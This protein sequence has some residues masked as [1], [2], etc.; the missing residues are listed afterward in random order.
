MMGVPMTCANC[1]RKLPQGAIVCPYCGVGL[2]DVPIQK[3]K[4]LFSG[5]LGIFML[6]GLM[7]SCIAWGLMKA[8]DGAAGA[9][10]ASTQAAPRFS[11]D[12]SDAMQT[13]RRD[14]MQKLVSTG[15]VQ[16]YVQ[17]GSHV[18][19]WITPAFRLLDFDQ[20]KA[21]AEV[22]WC[23]YFDGAHEFR[24]LNIHDS[25]SGKE[26]GDFNPHTGLDL[27]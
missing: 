11:V 17:R 3:S 9:I 10:Q 7:F 15:V 20:K 25:K 18:E 8:M 5:C 21:F 13:E 19:M 24:S 23:Y 22:V 6:G 4:G 14:M 26:I 16:K 12:K 27:K 2:G 1:K